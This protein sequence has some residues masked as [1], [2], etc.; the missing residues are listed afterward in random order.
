MSLAKIVTGGQTGV[1]RG[2]LDA[3]L[4]LNFPCGGWCPAD[5]AAEDGTIPARYPLSPLPG[6]GYRERTLQN[7]VDSDGT[8]IMSVAPL[9]G[10]TRLTRDLC[11]RRAKPHL[12][13]DAVGTTAA[14]AARRIAHF[15]DEHDIRVLNV[16]GPR[17]SEWREAHAFASGTIRA[18]L[19]SASA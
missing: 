10:G 11:R 3:A 19:T 15:I 17:S 2:A 5:R 14:D 16:A 18:L 4:A 7:V 6:A 13:M 9:R 1:D 12:V 8:V